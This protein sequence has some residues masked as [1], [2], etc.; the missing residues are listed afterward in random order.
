MDE[1]AVW[2]DGE[3]AFYLPGKRVCSFNGK[4]ESVTVDRVSA[5]VPELCEI[6]RRVNEFCAALPKL[7]RGSANQRVLR[8]SGLNEPQLDVGIEQIRLHQS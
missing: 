3:P 7:I 5:N 8:R 2:E 6:L 4:S 1:R